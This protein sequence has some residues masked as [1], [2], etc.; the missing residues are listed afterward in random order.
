[1]KSSLRYSKLIILFL[2]SDAAYKLDIKNHLS[3]GAVMVRVAYPALLQ[4]F[5]DGDFNPSGYRT[6]NDYLQ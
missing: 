6:I 2:Y 1:M 4:N 5:Y 3:F